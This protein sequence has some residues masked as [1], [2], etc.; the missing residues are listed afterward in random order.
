MVQNFAAEEICYKFLLIFIREYD[1]S[2]APLTIKR[3]QNL[4]FNFFY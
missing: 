2:N 3:G 4:I 1:Q